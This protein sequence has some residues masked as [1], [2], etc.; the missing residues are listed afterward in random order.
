MNFMR[1]VFPGYMITPSEDEEDSVIMVPIEV[2]KHHL[3]PDI[4]FESKNSALEGKMDRSRVIAYMWGT[5]PFSSCMSFLHDTYW[6]RM[7]DSA[8]Q[9]F[10]RA[11]EFVRTACF[12]RREW[13]EYSFDHRDDSRHFDR[14]WRSIHKVFRSSYREIIPTVEQSDFNF[15]S[16]VWHEVQRWE[17]NKISEVSNRSLNELLMKGL[18]IPI[19]N[20]NLSVWCWAWFRDWFARDGWF[21]AISFFMKAT[22]PYHPMMA[23]SLLSSLTC[24]TDFLC[25]DSKVRSWFTNCIKPY[26][27]PEISAREPPSITGNLPVTIREFIEEGDRISV[28]ISSGHINIKRTN[29]FT[30]RLRMFLRDMLEI[31]R[32]LLMGN[33]KP[34]S[35]ASECLSLIKTLFTIS[36]NT[37]LIVL[38]NHILAI[39]RNMREDNPDQLIYELSQLRQESSEVSPD[40]QWWSFLA[41]S[42]SEIES[43]MDEPNKMGRA[44][45]HFKGTC[46]EYLFACSLGLTF[47]QESDRP[48]MRDVFEVSGI[49]VINSRQMSNVP[50]FVYW[51]KNNSVRQWNW[52]HEEDAILNIT[53]VYWSSAPGRPLKEISKFSEILSLDI[54]NVIIRVMQ[55]D[56]SRDW[57][58]LFDPRYTA[59]QGHMKE[60]LRLSSYLIPDDIAAHVRSSVS[61]VFF[62]DLTTRPNDV[63]VLDFPEENIDRMK[64]RMIEESD[65]EELKE[66]RR[67]FY[68]ENIWLCARGCHRLK[69]DKPREDDI[70]DYWDTLFKNATQ[71]CTSGLNK[72]KFV[73]ATSDS[74]NDMLDRLMILQDEQP[75]HET[76]KHI[77]IDFPFLEVDDSMSNLTY[78]SRLQSDTELMCKHLQRLPRRG[79]TTVWHR[80]ATRLMVACAARRGSLFSV[81]HCGIL[82]FV[83]DR[84][85]KR[86]SSKMAQGEGTDPELKPKKVIFTASDESEAMKEAD[87]VLKHAEEYLRKNGRDMSGTQLERCREWIAHVKEK[88]SEPAREPGND[89]RLMEKALL[90]A[91]R[92]LLSRESRNKAE[93]NLDSVTFSGKGP[94]GGGTNYIL[95]DNDR[96]SIDRVM[97]WMRST[98]NRPMKFP[99]QEVV[100]E[101]IAWGK[102]TG[103]YDSV[104]ALE[105]VR[106][107]VKELIKRRGFRLTILRKEVAEACMS[108]WT[109][110][111][112]TWRSRIH[113]SYLKKSDVFCLMRRCGTRDKVVHC[114]LFKVGGLSEE[115]CSSDKTWFGGACPVF[116]V[117]EKRIREWESTPYMLVS[118]H[119]FLQDS[120]VCSN[121]RSQAFQDLTDTVS[122]EVTMW[123]MSIKR[124]TNTGNQAMRYCMMAILSDIFCY[125]L[126]EKL[127]WVIR[128][129]IE[130]WF[131]EKEVDWARRLIDCRGQIREGLANMTEPK[132]SWPSF[133]T[134]VPAVKSQSALQHVY[135]HQFWNEDFADFNRELIKVVNKSLSGILQYQTLDLIQSLSAH[136]FC[137]PE[138]VGMSICGWKKKVPCHSLYFES[139]LTDEYERNSIVQRWEGKIPNP[140]VASLGKN[141]GKVSQFKLT[142]DWDKFRVGV[143][144]GSLLKSAALCD[145]ISTKERIKSVA[146]N[147]GLDI[148]NEIEAFCENKSLSS[149]HYLEKIDLSH[150]RNS[151]DAD[152]LIMHISKFYKSW[153][154]KNSGDP[155][156]AESFIEHVAN[157]LRLPAMTDSLDVASGEVSAARTKEDD[158]KQQSIHNA[159]NLVKTS[160]MVWYWLIYYSCMSSEELDECDVDDERPRI[161]LHWFLNGLKPASW[162]LFRNSTATSIDMAIQNAALS[163]PNSFAHHCLVRIMR[164]AANSHK[165]TSLRSRGLDMPHSRE[166]YNILL[167]NMIEEHAMWGDS[168]AVASM[169][170]VGSVGI[171][172]IGISPKVQQGGERELSVLQVEPSVVF[173]MCENVVVG[174][175]TTVQS[176]LLA[177]PSNEKKF[178]LQRRTTFVENLPAIK[179]NVSGNS[180]CTVYIIWGSNDNATWAPLHKNLSFANMFRRL[181][182]TM[183]PN[184]RRWTEGCNLQHH[185]KRIEI[186]NSVMVSLAKLDLQI[187]NG[188]MKDSDLSEE[189]LFLLTQLR[190]GKTYYDKVGMDMCQGIPHNASSTFGNILKVPIMNMISSQVN[191]RFGLSLEWSAVQSSDDEG[192]QLRF[193]SNIPVRT[194]QMRQAAVWTIDMYNLMRVHQN[195]QLSPKSVW[196]SVVFELKSVFSFGPN[197][198][199][200]ATKFCGSQLMVQPCIGPSEI[201]NQ[202]WSTARS[203]IENNCTLSHAMLLLAR[204]RELTLRHWKHVYEYTKNMNLMCCGGIILPSM[205]DLCTRSAAAVEAEQLMTADDSVKEEVSKFLDED[206][207][208]VSGI[209]LGRYIYPAD[210][211]QKRQISRIK[212]IIGDRPA[213]C[214]TVETVLQSMLR[215]AT[216]GGGEQK[217]AKKTTLSALLRLTAGS[218]LRVWAKDYQVAQRYFWPG[219]KGE[220]R[221]SS[222]QRVDQILKRV[223]RPDLLANY[224]SAVTSVSE[225]KVPHL[226]VDRV[227]HGVCT[228]YVVK[229]I[230]LNRH[231]NNL[232]SSPVAIVGAIVPDLQ[233]TGLPSSA[234]EKDVVHFLKG[235]DEDGNRV[236]IADVADSFQF[237]RGDENELTE[238]TESMAS[239]AAAVMSAMRDGMFSF[240][241]QVPK[242]IWNQETI[243]EE[244][245][246]V[247]GLAASMQ[248]NLRVPR[249]VENFVY[250]IQEMAVRQHPVS[251]ASIEGSDDVA[252]WL[253]TVEHRILPASRVS[254]RPDGITSFQK[255]VDI[256][257]FHR[258]AV[259]TIVLS[260]SIYLRCHPDPNSYEC[261]RQLI[262]MLLRS[263]ATGLIKVMRGQ[264][265]SVKAC[266]QSLRKEVFQNP[267]PPN[268]LAILMGAMNSE[269]KGSILSRQIGAICTFAG[270]E[271]FSSSLKRHTNRVQFRNRTVGMNSIYACLSSK[272]WMVLLCLPTDTTAGK[273]GYYQCT[274]SRGCSPYQ[275]LILWDALHD[276]L[277]ID[278]PKGI[279][280][281]AT[282]MF[283]QPHTFSIFVTPDNSVLHR[284]ASLN[285]FKGSIQMPIHE[286]ELDLP[287]SEFDDLPMQWKYRGGAIVGER[288]ATQSSSILELTA[289]MQSMFNKKETSLSETLKFLNGGERKVTC[290]LPSDASVF[291]LCLIAASNKSFKAENIRSRPTQTADSYNRMT[292]DMLEEIWKSDNTTSKSSSILASLALTGMYNSFFSLP[293]KNRLAH[294]I[295]MRI[296]PD[297][298]FRTYTKD[299]KL[300]IRSV[301]CMWENKFDT[302]FNCDVIRF[303]RDIEENMVHFECLL[304]DDYRVYRYKPCEDV[305]IEKIRQIFRLMAENLT[306]NFLGFP[307]IVNYDKTRGGFVGKIRNPG[308]IGL[309]IPIGHSISIGNCNIRIDAEDGCMEIMI[310]ASERVIY[311]PAQPFV[312]PPIRERRIFTPEDWEEGS[313]TAWSRASDVKTNAGS[314]DET[315]FD[316]EEDFMDI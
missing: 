219:E 149:S 47:I 258:K 311:R 26:I 212:D 32:P 143:L 17:V 73:S 102:K 84:N 245:R 280:D 122:S 273:Q 34:A 169:K 111:H 220:D 187:Q 141:T 193:T 299:A 272:T 90:R 184:F 228:D 295:L 310:P 191:E 166:K 294:S 69:C 275:A 225:I 54:P 164:D 142:V 137:C 185:H 262:R 246:L 248:I 132:L 5:S 41:S 155:S 303:I 226:N 6:R 216:S 116:I 110:V 199:N 112:P 180:M 301:Q 38:R 64:E 314:D 65:S 134:K 190:S 177:N 176:E 208:G 309:S 45:V 239:E 33:R 232:T 109:G 59:L 284:G 124:G 104:L 150:F 146:K 224:L 11:I 255:W 241:L 161:F 14:M 215:S 135:M 139:F 13:L 55:L 179:N 61:T 154:K 126:P 48:T 7:E 197:V 237:V 171:P 99:L 283:R 254:L 188:T 183:P 211:T 18:K 253:S 49:P 52:V 94:Q 151:N 209:T 86:M 244:M 259:E 289:M 278:N 182:R 230:K 29:D 56:T 93:D 40:Q 75:L 250:T 297:R 129:P 160:D 291:S 63:N 157:L 286:S 290:D 204:S 24:G 288:M 249:A 231:S 144:T 315:E 195:I 53:E 200:A 82:S 10:K 123:V 175:N 8:V 77:I 238:M 114:T 145:N 39:T 217:F 130:R 305:R 1:A 131:F 292:G 223:P 58:S 287:M 51:T 22:K 117:T 293:G 306:V 9:S 25:G 158:F 81:D 269:L 196:G 108:V 27:D 274:V 71:R 168:H 214:V 30:N 136:G 263:S 42:C 78:W 268:F 207:S 97:H 300:I 233:S 256:S 267:G 105:H 264:D 153:S 198:Q 247:A 62:R 276:Q 12:S 147:K 106:E 192:M 189:Q 213:E 279:S 181:N 271:G 50:D 103:K 172:C 115:V 95:N 89:D 2:C 96:R 118:F 285:S 156:L 201:T 236:S 36:N 308:D 140:S 16:F 265:R 307:V 46:A 72:N 133:W 67:L 298:L 178:T 28:L 167:K 101:F 234:E 88:L 243:Y 277:M 282:C 159:N 222:T 316:M 257:A 229:T 302:V 218:T 173:Q 66:R 205:T 240:L 98:C 121:P 68:K 313:Q 163:S 74:L 227:D 119:L 23:N 15:N 235:I 296:P 44:I 174:Y 37:D 70:R 43:A 127:V 87:T 148:E 251:V 261:K 125:S 128:R 242:T 270:F 170:L 266:T 252:Q 162:Q 221:L 60:V 312:S 3:V 194:D 304:D 120:S 19:D 107:T 260:I 57:S 31:D 4:S 21:S 83:N 85:C 165:K 186:P 206:P 100:D 76:G 138:D 281:M 152:M 79:I 203:A 92:E 202:F 35:A 113:L 91:Y 20:S 210:S 80:L